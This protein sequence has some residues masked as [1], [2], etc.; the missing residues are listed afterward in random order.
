MKPGINDYRFQNL[1]GALDWVPDRFEVTRASAEFHGG[2]TRFTHLMA[3]L[4]QPG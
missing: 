1:E 3:P 4:G 2:R